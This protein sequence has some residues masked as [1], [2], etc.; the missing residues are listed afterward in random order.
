MLS[1]L[2]DIGLFSVAM[3]LIAGGVVSCLLP[4]LPGP[5]V[6]YLAM[7]VSAFIE[8]AGIGVLD[9]VIWGAVVAVVSIGDN[10][11]SV[12]A[13]KRAGGTKAAVWGGLA[14]LLVGFFV[15]PFGILVGPLLGAIAGEW[16]AT[17]EMRKAVKSGVWSFIGLLVGV[18]A[19]VAVCLSLGAYIIVRVI[20]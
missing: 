4:P 16:L 18:A 7:V 3:V 17:Q 9:L 1:S 19:K 2:Q 13:V 6:A 10:F 11:I 14:G 12:A 8:A 15:P 20:R 5:A